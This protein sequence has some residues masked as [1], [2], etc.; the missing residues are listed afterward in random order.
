MKIF[1]LLIFILVLI[2]ATACSSN[3]EEKSEGNNGSET[4][5]AEEEPQVVEAN[6]ILP[7]TIFP[8]EEVTLKVE[9]TQGKE[10][11]E[12]ANEVMFEIWQDDKEKSE[13]VEAKHEGNGIYSI[14]KLFEQDGMYYVQT[15]VTAR[16]MHV[17]P[18]KQLIVGQVSD[19]EM[20]QM[21][22]EMQEEDSYENHEHEESEGQ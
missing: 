7:D 4:V 8:K 9:V 3:T 13:M 17:M 20:K 15:H 1:Q 21:E 18:K 2:L 19:E 5:S 12:D 16:D 10:V 22:E 14:T 11:V 6:I